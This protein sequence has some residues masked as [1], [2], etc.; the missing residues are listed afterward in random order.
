MEIL[1]KEY[2]LQ[3]EKSGEFVGLAFMNRTA[4]TTLTVKQQRKERKVYTGLRQYTL[5][6]SS[7]RGGNLRREVAN[8]LFYFNSHYFDMQGRLSEYCP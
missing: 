7:W 6:K 2:L 5:P 1:G 4:E 8:N 3:H